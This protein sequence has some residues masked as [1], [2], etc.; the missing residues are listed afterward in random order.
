MHEVTLNIEL[1]QALGVQNLIITNACGGMNKALS[2]GDFVILKDFINF[3][4]SNP[5]VGYLAETTFP[6]MTEPF[7][8]DLRKTMRDVFETHQVPY[9]EGTYVSFMGP[10]Y[11]TKAE[12]KMLSQVWGCHRD[13]HGP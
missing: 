9:Q 5:L 6:D 8:I 2:P 1:F 4:P 13:V 11:E 7:D 10:Y 12:I 3:M